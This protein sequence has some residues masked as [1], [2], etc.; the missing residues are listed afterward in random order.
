MTEKPSLYEKT[1]F[2]S[3]DEIYQKHHQKI[4]WYVKTR[5]NV[6]SDA[7]DIIQQTFLGV[8][9][10]LDNFNSQH[11][12][13]LEAYVTSIAKYKVMDYIRNKYRNREN[14][15]K[16]GILDKF[17]AEEIEEFDYEIQECEEE[18]KQ[19]IKGLLP[20]K[21]W[22][23]FIPRVFEECSYREISKNLGIS[24]S[25]AY[26]LQNKARNILKKHFTNG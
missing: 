6:I 9:E 8:L 25:Y 3:F 23:V 19:K 17:S 21:Y 18:L 5:V 7:E 2:H 11:K 13:G 22:Q 1:G 15:V 4:E 16:D 20:E 24:K 12:N 26:V 10:K 14:L